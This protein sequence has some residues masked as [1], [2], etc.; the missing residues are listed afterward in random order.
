VD[1]DG[2]A[3]LVRAEAARPADLNRA[4]MSAAIVLSRLAPQSQ[5]LEQVFLDMTDA[6]AA[7]DADARKAA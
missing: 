2:D 7:A 1:E 4:A 6:S 5:T 3:L